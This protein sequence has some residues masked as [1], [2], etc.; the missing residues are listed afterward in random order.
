[1]TAGDDEEETAEEGAVGDGE[2]MTAEEGAVVGVIEMF[3]VLGRCGPIG[4]AAGVRV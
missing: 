4:T 3:V 1:M 2:G